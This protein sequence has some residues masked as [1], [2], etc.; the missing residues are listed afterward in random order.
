MAYTELSI[1]WKSAA[2]AYASA[3]VLAAD[4]IAIFIFSLWVV[5]RNSNFL[6]SGKVLQRGT[7]VYLCT[8]DCKFSYIYVCMQMTVIFDLIAVASGRNYFA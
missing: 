4:A 7:L 3:F 2:F 6:F 8:D 5:L 1:S